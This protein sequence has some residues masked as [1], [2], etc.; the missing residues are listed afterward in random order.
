MKILQLDVNKIEFKLLEPESKTYEKS[1]KKD[2]VIDNTLVLLISIEKNDSDIIAEKAINDAILFM[3]KLKRK[4][5]TLYPFA[6]LSNNLEAPEIALKI[7]EHMKQFAIKSDIELF[8]A[9]FGWNKQLS[10]DI[11]G[12]PL[13]E[14]SR[15]YSESDIK[16]N[17]KQENK[18]NEHKENE[19]NALKEE[20]KVK[21]FWYILNEKGELIEINKFDFLNYVNLK[22]FADYEIKKERIY[23]KPPVHIQL[24]KKLGI[25]DYEPGSDSGNLRFYPNGRLIKSLLENYVTNTAIDYGAVELETPLMY[26][27]NHKALNEYLNRFPSRHYIVKS[28][29]KDFFLR[30]SADFGQFLLISDSV[31][32]YRQMPFKFYE[33]TRYSF[34]REKSGELVGLKRLRAFTMPDMHTI[35][36]DLNQAEEEFKKQFNLCQK[37]LEDIGIDKSK[38]ETA[39]RFTQDFWKENKEFIISIVKKELKRPVLIEMWNYRYAYFDPKF[40]FNI[41]DSSDKATALS[42]VQIDHENGERYNMNYIDNTGKKRHPL[43]LH[44]SPSGAIERVIYALLETCVKNEKPSLPLWLSPTQ[45]RLLP[46]SDRFLDKCIEISDILKKKNIR[47]DIDDSESTLDKK[48][49]NAEQEWIPYMCVIGQKE[50][51]TNTLSVRMRIENK[52]QVISLNEL[53]EIINKKLNN[54]PRAKSSL[55]S[56]LSKRP[57]FNK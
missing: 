15:A 49:M 14:Q 12:H 7:F 31:I 23:S 18:N 17:K 21:S 1:D 8:A 29:D 39:I 50:I 56:L 42:T 11:K 9:P 22:K 54:M 4:K 34:R 45:I 33:L 41:I 53:V 28:D 44:C 36:M 52:N 51:D 16:Q 40:E 47:A 13:A 24:M 19:S 5:L 30:F 38:Y 10:I 3:D 46:I 43:V 20:E 25:S 55:S 2:V 48:I 6:H 32:S 37:V 57:I 27:Y 35:C 26:D